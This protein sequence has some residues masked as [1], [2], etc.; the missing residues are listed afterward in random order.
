MKAFFICEICVEN[1]F[2]F[3]SGFAGLGG[4]DER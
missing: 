2:I 4:N 3:C 1:K